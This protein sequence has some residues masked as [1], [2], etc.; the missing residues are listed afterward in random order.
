[1][2]QKTID[3][4]IHS[5]VSSRDESRP[6]N[7][8][9]IAAYRND[10]GQF[11]QYLVAQNVPCWSRVTEAHFDGYLH[12]MH[13]KH[14]YRPTTIARKLA[15]LKSFF[16]S[17]HTNGKITYNPLENLEIPRV[18]K[19]LPAVLSA[20]QVS[21]LFAQVDASLPMG[22]RDLA[23]MHLLYATGM[24]VTELVSLNIADFDPIG[25]TIFCP[26]HHKRER[27][28]PLS[29]VSCEAILHYL[30]TARP[31]LVMHHPD[32]QALF[33]NHHGERLTRQGF[34]LIIKRYARLAGVAEIT[35]H[36]LRHSFALHMLKQGMELRS[37]QRMLGHAHVATTQVYSQLIEDSTDDEGPPD[38]MSQ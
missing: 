13:E 34:W 27:I 32:E 20:E 16:R 1:M 24:R 31:T 15:A 4:Y 6:G 5:L 2:L 38:I 18:Q 33:V 14:G 23:M 22:R 3:D 29:L 12:E 17:L 10:L 30:Q 11:C 35:P 21:R 25:S 28:L 36:M 8:N 26:V 37:V 7:K 9:T 19:E